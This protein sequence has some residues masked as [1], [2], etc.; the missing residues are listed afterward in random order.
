MKNA[1]QKVTGSLDVAKDVIDYHNDHYFF[2]FFSLIDG[3][4]HPEVFCKRASLKN[5]ATFTGTYL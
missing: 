4:S 1:E 5:A 3:G 2:A